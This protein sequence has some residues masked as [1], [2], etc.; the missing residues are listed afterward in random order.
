MK[1]SIAALFLALIP[2]I[3]LSFSMP[4]FYDSGS[5]P[6]GIIAADINSDGT[7]E[8]VVANF[9]APTLIGQDNTAQ[10]PTSLSIFL[11]NGSGLNVS[12]TEF[13]GSLRGL[14]SGDINNDG[15]TDIVATNYTEGTAMIFLQENRVLKTPVGVETG[16]YPVGIAVGNC[17]DDPENE[18]AVAV[19][20]ENKVAIIDVNAGGYSVSYVNAGI[21]PTDVTIGKYKGINSII[22]ANYG[23]GGVSVIVKKD[24][25]YQA[26]EEIQTGGGTCKVELADLNKDGENEIIAA[27]FN[28]N[29]VS[30]A[31]KTGVSAI[32]LKGERP[33]GLAV[34]DINGDGYPDIITADRDS[35]SVEIFI[36]V[37][38]TFSVS[39]N[40]TVS[41][42]T[43]K[44]F[45][46]VEVAVSDINND[47]AQDILFTHMKTGRLGVIY[48]TASLKPAKADGAEPMTQANVYNYPNPA[49]EST[50][51]RFPLE[52]P[53]ETVITI[54]DINGIKVWE[55]KLAKSETKAGINTVI[56]Q[57]INGAGQKVGNGAYVLK[58]KA[59]NKIITKNIA[60]VK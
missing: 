25:V 42:E 20:G 8:A 46:P 60:V 32:K 58:V 34:N 49:S 52:E 2:S 4:V 44:T 30:V 36:N 39:E 13:T 37:N 54:T 16:K 15:K 14:A 41:D 19:Y 23:G 33:N 11:K 28:D 57:L 18:T 27:N 48:G 1:K 59:G 12:N 3:I 22:S 40:I 9:G 51:I 56:W 24:G 21:S 26:V 53:A 7:S 45:G 35:N 6:R 5:Y 38:G 55:K 47:G 17:D 50:T 10:A 43:D 31:G 29:T